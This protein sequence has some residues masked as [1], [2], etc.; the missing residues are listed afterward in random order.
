MLGGLP[1]VVMPD[2]VVSFADLWQEAER[3]AAALL[4]AGIRE[5]TAVGL[6]H[7]SSHRFVAA[8]LALCRLDSSVALLSPQYGVAELAPIVSGAGVE[9]IVAD[10]A[11]ARRIAAALPIVRAAEADGLQVLFTQAKPIDFR[12]AIVK[13]SSGSTCEPKGIAL[14]AQN[15]LTEAENVR[16]TL[17]L[18]GGER[19]FADVPISHSYGF[20]CAVLQTLYAGTTLV[21]D[22]AFAPRRRFAAVQGA[23]VF[24]GAPAHYRTFLT[25]PFAT[26]PD[27]S[28]VR[29]LLSCT[30]PLSVD[31]VHA[32]A[33]RFGAWICQHYG[34]SE[35]GAITNH[36]PE[37]VARRPASV[38]R[39]LVGVGVSI[40][41]PDGFRLPAG[42]EGEVVV[43][44]GAL[45]KG[46]VLGEPPGPSPFRDGRFWTGDV[47]VLD[48]VGYLTLCGRRDAM[49]N[50][51]GLKVS[52]VEVT[53]VLERHPQV[54]EAAVL[55]VPDRLGE[56]VTYGVVALDGPAEEAEL[57]AFCRERLAE[58]KVP[59]RIE[60]R[61][62]LPRSAS[63]KVRIK[64]D[65]LAR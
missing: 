17:G 21:L 6:S 43:E 20:D 33:E 13:F 3:L 44:S 63:G 14:D 34:S 39:P 58:H 31:V 55:G 15:V 60:I 28:Q 42:A 65:D 10:P 25:I 8:L 47:G 57:I 4:R 26:P 2:H 62:E 56:E 49:I 48:D 46:Y 36:L 9:C 45:A 29:W 53:A 37:Q 16:A 41:G 40:V 22:E 32:F 24:L 27:L 51:G 11:G 64:Q 59:R 7:P 5:S 35:T 18:D 61:D 52:P 54:R 19:V 50:V 38:G 12:P 1:A 30:A 23:N